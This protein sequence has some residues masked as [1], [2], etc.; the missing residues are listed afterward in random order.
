MTDRGPDLPPSANE[1]GETAP[2]QVSPA[3]IF[4]R[5]ILWL[6]FL[7]IISVVSATA[8]VFLFFENRIEKQLT[9]LV[10][11]K[12]YE[13]YQK[14]SWAAQRHEAERKASESQDKASAAQVRAQTAFAEAEGL[15]RDARRHANELVV[16]MD[17]INA[18]ADI[19]KITTKLDEALA[20]PQFRE[21]VIRRV[22][23]SGAVI[24]FDLSQGCPIGWSAFRPGGGRTIIGAGPNSNLDMSGRPLSSYAVG[25]I[26][27]EES[28][29]LSI[30]ETPA[31]SHRVYRHAAGEVQQGNPGA[32]WVTGAGS[33]DTNTYVKDNWQTGVTGGSKPHNI[34]APYIA[35]YFCKKNQ[36]S[37]GWKGTAHC[38]TCCAL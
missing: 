27:G 5:N 7:L 8:A 13:V 38:V 24:A 29:S 9:T 4:Q 2:R 15:A 21:E 35:L 32:G 20:Q 25:E 23:P 22:L 1:P 12:V 31:H 10:P 3:D 26:G 28:H 37:A 11:L 19:S 18:F 6:A 16:K 30:D 33:G 34:R 36:S 17:Q 14:D